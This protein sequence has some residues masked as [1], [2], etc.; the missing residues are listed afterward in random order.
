MSVQDVVW[1]RLALPPL[2]TNET[3]LM[4]LGRK[5]MTIEAFDGLLFAS[6]LQLLWYNFRLY[7]YLRRIPPHILVQPS[8]FALNS[9][10]SLLQ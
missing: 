7:S 9:T 4:L 6:S 10:E 8:K 3:A 1:G 2:S 5:A